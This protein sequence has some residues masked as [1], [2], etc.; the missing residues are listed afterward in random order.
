MPNNTGT[1][2]TAPIRPASD[3]DT[4][5]SAYSN[6][7]LGGHHQVSTLSE[8]NLIS[9]E[10][11]LEG[12]FCAVVEDAG[13]Y[14]LQG[15][16]SNSNWVNVNAIVSDIAS[17]LA[18]ETIIR[19]TETQILGDQIQDLN[20][21]VEGLEVGYAYPAVKLV[22]DLPGGTNVSTA[23]EFTRVYGD[24]ALLNGD[25]YREVGSS[26]WTMVPG[27][28]SGQ[29][30]ALNTLTAPFSI[31]GSLWAG[32][33]NYKWAI[34]D[35][36]NRLAVGITD[37]GTWVSVHGH[38]LV[39]SST[40]GFQSPADKVA[41]DDLLYVWNQRGFENLPFTVYPNPIKGTD[42]NLYQLTIQDEVGRIAAGVTT[43]GEWK[44]L[45]THTNATTSLAGFQSPA[46]KA[47]FDSLP[48]NIVGSLYT[49][50][51]QYSWAVTDADNRV[52]F[53][54]LVDGTL[55]WRSGRGPIS[56]AQTLTSLT[57]GQVS[58]SVRTDLPEWAY[59]ITDN[60]GRIALG[61]KNDGTTI[62]PGFAVPGGS[63]GSITETM[64]ATNSVSTV[65]LQPYSVVSSKLSR[66]LQLETANDLVESHPDFVRSQVG[67]VGCKTMPG[68][69][70]LPRRATP[71]LQGFNI[72]GTTLDFR[73]SSGLK[74]RGQRYITTW[75]P[76]INSLV[77]K[78][79]FRQAT[80]WPPAGSFIA[81]DYYYY[82]TPNTRVID[83]NTIYLGDSMVYNGT[84]WV[85]SPAPGSGTTRI[86]LDWWE[87]S[88]GA[89]F[90]G[91]VYATNDKIVYLGY[92]SRAVEGYL[93]FVK[94]KPEVNEYF[95]RG[96]F[97]PTS[98]L[99]A[100]PMPGD[101]YEASAAG[102]ISS[103]SFAIGDEL[104]RKGTG[105]IRVPTSPSITFTSSAGIYLKCPSGFSDDYEVRRA[106]K[107]TTSVKVELESYGIPI[108][109]R[110]TG[111]YTLIGDS[112]EAG[113]GLAVANALEPLGLV[114]NR[115]SYGGGTAREVQS[116]MEKF[117]LNG[118]PYQG[119]TLVTVVGQ[120]SGS[121]LAQNMEVRERMTKLMGSV[122]RRVI[123]VSILGS[124]NTTWNGTR[125]VISNFEE[126]LIPGSTNNVA[127]DL[128]AL[129]AAWP[130]NYF[131]AAKNLCDASLT[132][133]DPSI[134]FPGMT[135][136]QVAATYGIPPVKYCRGYDLSG[137][138]LSI[139]NFLGY[140][141]DPALPTGGSPGDYYLRI[142]SGSVGDPVFNIAGV[143]TEK[144]IVDSIHLTAAGDTIQGAGVMALLVSKNWLNLS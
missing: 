60:S 141:T 20:D 49:T 109:R 64:L 34:L 94:G 31:V 5:P 93:T 102:T 73:L 33:V 87:V 4:F 123:H 56:G 48:F 127:Q 129:Q 105:W 42:G 107:G 24:T 8:R 120:N 131:W 92:E 98:A 46:D 112:M 63:P 96:T 106:D 25:Y 99:P 22:A 142:N 57:I 132:D 100:T 104:I 110:G 61:I 9:S 103:M 1:L 62:I 27:S 13:L 117:I 15:G 81:G 2:V 28:L 143:W 68:W 11:R 29:V 21:I 3:L 144:P 134:Q 111:D 101:I 47:R 52:A 19:E 118:D 137:V 124:R 121:D 16:I 135:N 83:G 67:F 122:D 23:V 59:T 128:A 91:V 88:A 115:F 78:G 125:L 6:E 97:D 138:N 80:S 66:P 136:A 51:G 30:A 140:R 89:T 45:H 113:I 7:L 77:K 18:Q 71:S 126:Q 74:I 38:P 108:K 44:S 130:D 26:V 76:T 86:D 75:T 55:N 10:R 70:M 79:D 39:T 37:S 32:G 84:S 50:D 90:E 85:Y 53:G 43:S 65:K 54:V 69:Q 41:F 95:R 119:D 139:L 114:V 58:S 14:Q 40:S 116:M 72:A 82:C 36:N 12:M 133:N 35:S 17:D